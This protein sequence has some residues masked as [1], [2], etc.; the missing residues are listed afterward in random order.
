L[1]SGLLLLPPHF[2][3]FCYGLTDNL[4]DYHDQTVVTYNSGCTAHGC[5][6]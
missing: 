4:E 6:Q 1:V 5:R 2:N 3:K